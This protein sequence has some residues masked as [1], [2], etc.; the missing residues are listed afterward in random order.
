MFK[1]LTGAMTHFSNIDTMNSR[2]NR[3]ASQPKHYVE[4]AL[5]QDNQSV[6]FVENNNVF[7]WAEKKTLLEKNNLKYIHA[8]RL[9]VTDSLDK[10]E[11]VHHLVLIAKNYDGVKEI[12]NIISE[13]FRGRNENNN[14]NEVNNFYY[15]PRTE[16]ARIK[17][18]S[19]NVFIVF[20]E[21]NNP[22][23]SNKRNNIGEKEAKWLELLRKE[24]VILGVSAR[25]TTLEYK[26]MNEYFEGLH[27]KYG[28]NMIHLDLN[29][30]HKPEY[31]YLRF[32]LNKSVNE[33]F[34]SNE[35]QLVAMT[36]Q[37]IK[38]G[39]M[40]YFESDVT[41][42]IIENSNKLYD[43]IENF[44][45][46]LSFK[47]PSIYDENPE[48]KLKELVVEG[49]KHRGINKLDKD[50]QRIYKER[51]NHEFDTM[52]TTHA[53]NYMLLEQNV[54]QNMREQGI[55]SGVARGSAGASLIGYLL[56]ITDINP[57]SDKLIFERF[58]NKDRISLADIDSDWAK[59]DRFTVQQFLLEHPKLNCASVIT[60]GTLGLKGAIKDIGKALG[61]SFA[62]MNRL[63]SKVQ[64]FGGKD[65][66][67]DSDKKGY[68]LLFQY[69][70]ELIGTITHCGRH[71]GAILV[72]SG[73]TQGEIGT[74]RVKKFDY[75]VIMWDMS[76]VEKNNY[77]KLDVLGLI[78]LDYI[79]IATELANIDRLHSQAEH[80]D[81][82][83]W[84]IR[85]EILEY[86]VSTIFQ[87]PNQEEAVLTALSDNSVNRMRKINPDIRLVDILSMVTAAI[88]PGASSV[89]DDALNGIAHD[90][91]V[92][93]INEMMK[94]TFGH[95]LY[96]EQTIALIQYAGFTASEADVIRRAIGKKQPEVIN[97]WIPS[98]RQKL[99]DKIL[100]DY[101]E[102]DRDDVV[103]MV[104]GLAQSIID[105]SDYSFNKAHAMAYSYISIET[106]WLRHYY[107][108][109][110]LTANYI[111]SGSNLDKVAELNKLAQAKGIT[112]E[113]P[114]FGRSKGD[115]F[116][117][118]TTNTI[119]EGTLPIKGSNTQV[120]DTLYQFKDIEYNYFSE[121]LMDLTD[122]F[123]LIGDKQIEWREILSLSEE[124]IKELD[125][126]IKA[127]T[128]E[129][130]RRDIQTP[131]SGQMLA[132]IRLGFFREFGGASYLE[133]V[134][135]FFSKKYRKT[136]KTMKSKRNNYQTVL[137]FEKKLDKDEDL[138][139][140]D[141]ANY[142]LDYLE[143]CIIKDD[144]ISTKYA[145]VTNVQ[146]TRGT[147]VK[148]TVH[149]IN[150]GRTI[151]AKVPNKMHQQVPFE[152]GDVIEILSTNTSPATELI[153]G[154]WQKSETKKDLWINS[155][156]YIRKGKR[157]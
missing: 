93:E 65:T 112:M 28:V 125:K 4:L 136:N 102:K 115:Y 82:N 119:Y 145:I 40:Q 10:S 126:E 88:R 105:S 74:V 110:W 84:A 56:Q 55:Y 24:N 12:N 98:F 22:L 94:D 39:L 58:M 38:Q 75:P 123:Y 71:A 113:R 155:L 150:K 114:T 138:S 133:K 29:M 80:I 116:F 95:L 15:V 8:T 101:P 1:V 14:E 18:I 118:K 6:M 143:K 87:L 32:L 13:S 107:P 109:E 7:N 79:H 17:D 154:T 72:Y 21:L 135:D 33:Q 139:I 129:Y 122:N 142:E 19:D 100:N 67:S 85:D 45:M 86:G 3:S 124:R 144:R 76:A 60:Y 54:K 121:L 140:Y 131:N 42:S 137:D 127:N 104:N 156:K 23:W 68:E 9:N 117:N 46:D 73:D 5:E 66:I 44:K 41:K 49:Y 83:D 106:A 149:S 26:A 48:Q 128:Y 50:T 27:V 59:R 91:G 99:V 51:I 141:K 103:E 90:Y 37:Q 69:V 146:Q 111:V 52:K 120:G 157:E 64:T 77:V 152:V 47:Y 31:E 34:E 92:K 132:L 96:Q 151:E 53:I 153:N 81:Y 35:Q 57:I 20:C 61:Y 43:D 62:E 130:V 30:S 25:D 108:L 148:A 16:L 2:P 11:R 78:N 63:T 89:R 134:Y 97:E 36:P 70:E 147:F